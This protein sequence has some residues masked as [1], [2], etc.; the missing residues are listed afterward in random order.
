MF[1]SIEYDGHVPAN[2]LIF[3]SP[4]FEA[5]LFHSWDP[6][7][8]RHQARITLG[9]ATSRVKLEID[10]EGN[11]PTDVWVEVFGNLEESAGSG[12]NDVK[13]LFS[14]HG[15]TIPSKKNT[16]FP[17]IPILHVSEFFQHFSASRF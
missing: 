4:I 12:P 10:L 6:R 17:R 9:G 7:I 2:Q 13:Q 1:Q 5:V 8:I 16:R 15:S 14:I 11:L 3:F